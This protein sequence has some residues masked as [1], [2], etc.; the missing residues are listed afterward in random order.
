MLVLAAGVL[1]VLAFAAGLLVQTIA[2]LGKDIS[3][4]TGLGAGGQAVAVLSE[5]SVTFALTFSVFLLLY[6]S[7]PPQRSRFAALWPGAL[8]ASVAF[9]VATTVYG[10]YL[11]NFSDFNAIYGTLGALLGFLVVNYVGSDG[12]ARAAPSSCTPGRRATRRSRPERRHLRGCRDGG[13]P[14]DQ[15]GQ[16][17][18]ARA[19]ARGVARTTALARFADD[20]AHL[21]DVVRFDLPRL[22]DLS[23][24]EGVHLQCHIGTDTVSLARLGARMTGLD[25]SAAGDRRRPAR[26]PRPPGPTRRSSSP[27]STTRRRARARALRPRLHRHRRALLAARR[28]ALGAASSPTLLRPGG[29]LFIRE[30]HPML[31]S[32]GGPAARRPARDRV[33]VLRA[34]RAERLGRRAARTSR[35]TPSSPTTVTH[36]WNHGLGEIVTALLDAGLELTMLEEHDSVPWEA[37]PGQMERDAASEWRLDRPPQPP[38]AQLHAAGAAQGRAGGPCMIELSGRRR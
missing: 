21:S 14:G 11:T 23:G 30:G 38:A 20:P 8:L 13:L 31:W 29:R 1:A 3:T 35:P 26:S 27:T 5:A 2:S 34:A 16:L 19:R 17:G 12:P 4:L 32:L 18:R 37:L 36:E 25:F 6:R 28:P 22:G 24:L 15:P 10:I 9:N 7:V 33:P